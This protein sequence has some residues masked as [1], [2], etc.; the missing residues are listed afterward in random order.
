MSVSRSHS[1]APTSAQA[2][3]AWRGAALWS[4]GF[5]PFFLGAAVWSV[6]AVGLWPFVYSGRLELASAFTPIDWHAHEM[7]FGYVAAVAAGFLMTAVPNWT[8]RLPVAGWRLAGLAALWLAGRIAMLDSAHLGRI[9]AAA[10]DCS[11]LVVF[12]GLVAREVVAGRNWRNAKVVALVAALAF[13]NLAFHIEDAASGLA[14]Y[15]QRGAL[16]LVVM[17]IL[18]VGGRVTPSFTNNWLARAG[19]PKRPAPFGRLDVGV[20]ALSAL[21]LAVW[22][23]NPYGPAVGGLALAAGVGNFIRLSRWAGLAA[24]RD[25]LI[26]VLHAGFGLAA[27]GFVVAGTAALLPDVVPYDAA[28]HVFAIGAAGLMTLAMMTRATLGH[29]GQPLA[30]TTVTKA[31][32]AL[33]L[34]A[35]L[36]RVCLSFSPRLQTPLLY[37]AACAWI[38]AFACFLWGYAPLLTGK[39]DIPGRR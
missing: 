38:L 18:L 5:R 33:V 17:L 8:G 22:T 31:A 14:V 12:A 26:L 13:A 36:L 25:A 3:R 16:A 2:I 19:S 4:R 11:F 15:S 20:M 10:I 29:S 6:V 7:I 27:F 32:Y 28:V 37:A 9:L 35:L 39:A 21:A 34:A 23:W 1:H 24:R 30:A